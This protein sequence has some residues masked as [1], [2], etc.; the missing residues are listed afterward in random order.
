VEEA[1][2]SEFKACLG[3]IQKPSLKTTTK[4]IN[5]HIIIHMCFQESENNYQECE[6]ATYK[7]G[8]NACDHVSNR[9]NVHK[10]YKELL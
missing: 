5:K 10:I 4:I 8:K 6:K 1:G 9:G 2:N 3:Y 7:I